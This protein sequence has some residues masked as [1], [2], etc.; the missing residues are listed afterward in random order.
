MTS[1]FSQVVFNDIPKTYYRSTQVTCHYTLAVGFLPTTRDW[2]GIYKVGWST[3][4]DYLSFVWVDP[5]VE[6]VEQEPM[7]KQSLFSEYYLPKEESEFYQFCYVDSLGYV[8]GASTPFSFQNPVENMDCSMETDLMVVTTQDEIDR[9]EREKE[10]LRQTLEQLRRGTRG[11]QTALEER[12]REVD[13]LKENNKERDQRE[14]DL[15]EELKQARVFLIEKEKEAERLREEIS[16]QSKKHLDPD[17]DNFTEKQKPEI[18]KPGINTACEAE[19]REKYDRAVVQIRQLKVE[20]EKQR[21][22]ITTSEEMA[23]LIPKVKGEEKEELIRL[24]DT[25]QLLEVDLKCSESEKERLSV[26][27]NQLKLL[28][29]DMEKLRSENQELRKSLSQQEVRHNRPDQDYKAQCNTMMGQL[30]NARTQLTNERKECNDKRRLVEEAER[31][32]LNAKSQM[33]ITEM[34]NYR[35]KENGSKLKLRLE[36]SQA[37]TAEKVA[38]IAEMSGIIELRENRLKIHNQEREKLVREHQSGL[39]ESLRIIAERESQIAEIHGTIELRENRLKIQN[40]EKEQLVRDNQCLRKTIEDL[41]REQAAGGSGSSRPERP[42]HSPPPRGTGSPAHG[43]QQNEPGSQFEE[44]HN[45]TGRGPNTQETRK[46]CRS[47]H[48]SFPGI[49]LEELEQHEQSHR[50]CPFCTLICDDMGQAEFEDHVY[51]HEI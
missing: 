29:H 40:Q 9:S 11:V 51:S 25:N 27:L 50:V 1:T 13:R 26:E 35:I 45:T 37:N 24:K 46:V 6:L 41:R 5:P 3:T 47:C 16:I 28:I 2:V 22:R 38:E 23:D 49:T 18:S 44:P 42:A 14:S 31:E 33:H 30:E 12:Q 4:K 7:R 20:L 15:V 10:E 19:L 17:Q 21:Q 8:K 39:A 36:E 34:E 43:L 32:L 48:M